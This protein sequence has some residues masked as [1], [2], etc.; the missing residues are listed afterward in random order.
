MIESSGA[1]ITSVEGHGMTAPEAFIGLC[2]TCNNSGTCVYR[3]RRGTDA[4]Y[5]ELYDGYAIPQ[6]GHGSKM[7][8]AAVVG[9]SLDAGATQTRGLC[10]NCEHRDSCQLAKPESGVWH[11]E[12]YE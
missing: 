10:V 4:I 11:C 9:G 3:N 8:G 1:Q 7:T 2:L 5:C 6:N 12:E